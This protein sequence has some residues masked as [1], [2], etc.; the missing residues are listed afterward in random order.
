MS[1]EP[2]ISNDLFIL[3]SNV[4]L[5]KKYTP[6]EVQEK[7]EHAPKEKRIMIK[8]EYLDLSLIHI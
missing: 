7:M 5:D 3:Y 1:S 6:E 8:T 2:F 4:V